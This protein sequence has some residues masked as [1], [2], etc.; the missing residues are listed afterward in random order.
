MI[1]TNNEQALRIK[2]EDV[3]LDEVGTLTDTLRAELIRANRLGKSGV[4]LAAPQIGI[5][6]KI[7]IIL[8]N[9]IEINLVNCNIEK[10]FD[11]ANFKQEGCLSFPGRTEDTVRFQ[12]IYVINNLIYP[13]SF[14]ATGILSVVCQHEIDHLN[15]ILFFDR[16]G[17]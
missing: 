6:K 10:V 8:A 15:Q 5:A 3:L 1:I 7:A 17:S 9:D 16:K 11:P 14:I 12:E 13:H 4:G 2:C